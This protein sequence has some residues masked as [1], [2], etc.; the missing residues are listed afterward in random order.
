MRAVMI[1]TREEPYADELHFRSKVH[2]RQ[3]KSDTY[4]SG[5][6]NLILSEGIYRG[7]NCLLIAARD[8]AVEQENR[9]LF[10]NKPFRISFCRKSDLETRIP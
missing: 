7:V 10:A 2:C 4:L 3:M 6:W 1:E 9:Y 5:L 8:K